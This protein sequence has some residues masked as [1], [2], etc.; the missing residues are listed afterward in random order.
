MGVFRSFEVRHFTDD[1]AAD[2]ESDFIGPTSVLD[3][4]E[5]IEFLRALA[6]AARRFFGNERWDRPAVPPEQVRSALAAFKPRP[7]PEVRQRI[8]VNK[9]RWIGA[10]DRRADADA[11]RRRREQPGVAADGDGVLRFVDAAPA[12]F[13]FAPQT[14]RF[15]ARLRVRRTGPACRALRVLVGSALNVR[16]APGDCAGTSD[17]QTVTIPQDRWCDLRIEVALD[18][19]CPCAN[20]ELDGTRRLSALPLSSR[21]AVERVTVGGSP[22]WELADVW[23]QSY[24]DTRQENAQ[25][26]LAMTTVLAEDFFLT[27]SLSGW[28]QPDYDDSSWPEAEAPFAHGGERHRGEDLYLRHSF[29]LPGSGRVWLSC[30]TLFPGGE[31]W[32]N[33]RVLHVQHDPRPVR[34]EITSFV[35]RGEENLLAIR[36]FPFVVAHWIACGCS[37]LNSGWFAGRCWIDV[38]HTNYIEDLFATTARLQPT[39]TLRIRTTVTCGDWRPRDSQSRPDADSIHRLRLRVRPWFPEEGPVVAESVRELRLEHFGRPLVCDTELPIPD[40][41]PW[42]PGHPALYRIDAV[43][44]DAEGRPLDDVTETT[45]LRTVDQEGGVFRLNGRP[46]LLTGGL[47][48]GMR[49]PL[50]EQVRILRCA[51]FQHLVREVLLAKNLGANCIR[52]S[53]H[54]STYLGCNDP[55]L[56]ELGD[57]L[58]IC[59]LWT[60]TAWVRTASAWQL[61]PE[62]L[63]ADA[64]LVRNHPSIVM[65]Q[66]GNHPIFFDGGMEW[67]R[68]VFKTLLAVDD[69]RLICPVGCS[70]KILPP[71]DDGT[72]LRDGT[73]VEPE[74]TWIHPLA[75]RGNFEVP[76]GYEKGWEYLRQW[77]EPENWQGDFGWINTDFKKEYLES[78]TH[79]WFDFESEETIG[80]PNWDLLK[81]TPVY[82]LWSYEHGYDKASIGRLLDFDEWELSQAWQALSAIEAYRKKR[83]LDYDGMFWCTLDG[84]GNTGTYQKPLTDY[85]GHAKIA[86]HAVRM[87]FQPTFAGSGNVDMSYGPGDVVPIRVIHLGPAGRARVTVSV[88]TPAGRELDRRSWSDVVLP[89]GRSV[90]E[91]ADWRPASSLCGMLVLEYE[92]D[93]DLK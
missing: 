8:R 90:V 81:G 54:E 34:L 83:L 91:V 40:G 21:S 85:L 15:L 93:L 56:A 16:L 52:M 22:G 49:P 61:D 68:D 78:P 47:L 55:R 19:E 77:P 64:G 87:V 35:R 50:E 71:S 92:V 44:E 11:L 32:I 36:V 80:Q 51:P 41:E 72:R 23:V 86:Y 20:V 25:T 57:Q 67:W 12:D 42:E 17:A 7:E 1:P 2:G 82:H 65:W 37:D 53:V 14:W 24:A 31:I 30:E 76:T 3:T 43:L 75:A 5:R 28:Q 89:A 59:F 70:D 27:P 9:W 62:L 66:P 73:T 63:A 74:P 60:T 33:G 26:P 29:R 4:P 46:A 38:T 18:D 58:G 6:A 39:P 45:G 88:R 13:T 69:S 79:A 48:F 84:G 10:R